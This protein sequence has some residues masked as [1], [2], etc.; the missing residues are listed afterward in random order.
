MTLLQ[1]LTPGEIHKIAQI[2]ETV[3][4]KAGARILQK[5]E[6]G[7]LFF[8][9]K[10]GQAKVSNIGANFNENTLGPGDYFGEQAL[11]TNSAREADVFA[12]T[13]LQVMFRPCYILACR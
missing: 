10:S 1:E 13:D 11:L 12:S 4:Y 5:G 3:P 8:M 2:V 9:I 6:Q 7:K